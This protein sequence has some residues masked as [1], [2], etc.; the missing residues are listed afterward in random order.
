[1]EYAIIAVIAALFVGAG[2]KETEKIKKQKGRMTLKFRKSAAA[3]AAVLLFAL[4]PLSAAAETWSA[5]SLTLQ[6]PE[7][8]VQFGPSTPADDPSWALAGVG[9]PQQ[10]LKDYQ[11]MNV[12]ADFITEDGKTSIQVMKKA[13]DYAESVYNLSLLN[14]EEKQEVLSNLV[15][16]NSADMQV[17]SSYY[18]NSSVP[19]YRIQIDGKTQTGEAHELVYGTII[20]GQVYNFDLYTGESAITPEQESLMRS[21]VDSVKFTE[22]L[23]KPEVTVTA[24][25]LAT[26]LG[27]LALLVVVILVPIIYFPLRNRRDKKRKA[28]LAEKLTEYHK[29]HGNNDAIPGEMR[30]ANSTD[31]TKE[32]IHTFSVYQAYVKNIGS[33]VV[34]AFLSIA[35]LAVSF[36]L[37]SEW[38]IKL[39]AVAI[40]GYYGYKIFSMPHTLE[41]IQRKVFQRGTSDT[42]RY[43][44]YDEAFRVSGIQSAS[45]FPYFQI[46]DARRHGQ[47]IYLY[48]GPDNAY[49]ID[50]YGFSL[51]EY[52]DF[53]K[54]IS[55][56]TGKKL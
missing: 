8:V 55:E 20:N 25:D 13:S 4:L 53:V 41:K 52:E 38:W 31:C 23:E 14:E 7:G 6:V 46:T 47:Y 44:F 15:K 2:Q 50:R 45:V 43:A 30:F 34:G 56:K 37:N 18:E 12:L 5:D 26:T 9:D 49:L 16:S 27:L 40:A 36:A 21:I 19:F 28:Q 1:M 32:A 22:I 48:Y 11:E 33:L 29:T 17:E 24:A 35:T 42:A 10:K 54:F 39:L 3:L 51:G